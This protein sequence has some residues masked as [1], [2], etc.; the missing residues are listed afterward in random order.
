MRS[1]IPL[2]VLC[3]STA[4]SE[5]PQTD[6]S[7]VFTD[8]ALP[9][10]YYTFT[11]ENADDYAGE[12]VSSAGDVDGDGKDDLLV[13]APWNDDGGSDAGKAYLVLGA[14]VGVM[15]RHLANADYIFLGERL[16]DY[17]GFGWTRAVGDVNGDGLD[18]V[19]LGAPYSDD[20][21]SDAGKATL[22]LAPTEITLDCE[23]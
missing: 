14:S 3:L 16:E 19:L 18:D 4:C 10:A 6:T 20:G 13:G 5:A 9:H 21:G 23:G 2:A 1:H 12:S 8:P 15:D 17:V 7:S 22:L 11:G